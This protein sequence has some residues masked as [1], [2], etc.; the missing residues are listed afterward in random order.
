MNRRPGLVPVSNV[1]KREPTATRA[2][3]HLQQPLV[4]LQEAKILTDHPVRMDAAAQALMNHN[5]LNHKPG[6]LG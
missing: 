4:C 3:W 1:Q 2:G 6:S 5:L